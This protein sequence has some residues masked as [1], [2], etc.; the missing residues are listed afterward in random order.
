MFR[1]G[2][3]LK[4]KAILNHLNRDYLYLQLESLPSEALVDDSNVI[5]ESG[6]MFRE[7]ETRKLFRHKITILDQVREE[8]YL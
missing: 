4:I 6:T 1:L 5:L 8:Q 2:L 7:I 3:H